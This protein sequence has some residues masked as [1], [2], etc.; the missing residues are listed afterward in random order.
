[1]LIDEL[2]CL[3]QSESFANRSSNRK[4]IDRYLSQNSMRIDYKETAVNEN[5]FLRQ[6]K[7]SIVEFIFIAIEQGKQFTGV[8]IV[9][10]MLFLNIEVKLRSIFC[11]FEEYQIVEYY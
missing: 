6:F 11:S 10:S 8:L 5:S 7:D 1:M 4:V 9:R 2:E 3:H